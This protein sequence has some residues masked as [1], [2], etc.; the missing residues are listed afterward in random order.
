MPSYNWRFPEGT[1]MEVERLN[2]LA[3]QLTGLAQRAAEL[4][5]YL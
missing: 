4:R 1:A 2:I 5:R 3:A